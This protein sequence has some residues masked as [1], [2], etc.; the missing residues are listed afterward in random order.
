MMVFGVTGRREGWRYRWWRVRGELV[1]E[2][3]ELYGT[4]G[5]MGHWLRARIAAVSVERNEYTMR[6]DV[7]DA[8]LPLRVP[9]FYRD[10]LYLIALGS[11]KCS[12]GDPQASLTCRWQNYGT[13]LGRHCSRFA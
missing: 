5:R 11:P 4:G 10:V 7:D 6:F 3:G 8:A 13:I 12:A 9:V 2:E 1:E